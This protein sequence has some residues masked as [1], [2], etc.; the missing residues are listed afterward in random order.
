MNKYADLAPSQNEKKR[1]IMAK[2]YGAAKGCIRKV[3]YESK[4]DADKAVIKMTARHGKQMKHYLC[5]H[6]HLWH[7]AT[8]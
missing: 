7:L 3:A 5:P 8:V 1:A 2:M 4:K 6:C